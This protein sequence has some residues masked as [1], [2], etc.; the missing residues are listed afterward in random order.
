VKKYLSIDDF[1]SDRTPEVQDVLLFAR[2]FIKK[3]NPDVTEELQYNCPFFS[4][5]GKKLCYLN[6][7]K[8]SVYIGFVDGKILKHPS[9]KSEGRSHIKVFYLD[10]DKD[11]KVNKLKGVLKEAVKVRESMSR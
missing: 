1:I 10:T 5:K 2:G 9:L 3:F 8:V 4:Y 6:S 11:I 7:N